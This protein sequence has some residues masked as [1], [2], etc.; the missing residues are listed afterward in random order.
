MERKR[1]LH[2]A[3][4]GGRSMSAVSGV[5]HRDRHRGIR[6]A[7]LWRARRPH[8]VERG[9][10][11][12]Y[13]DPR[14]RRGASGARWRWRDDD[15]WRGDNRRLHHGW[16]R[17]R[18]S[19]G[20]LR[21]A[22]SR[23]HDGRHLSLGHCATR[24]K[25]CARRDHHGMVR[26]H[27]ALAHCERAL[28]M[29]KLLSHAAARRVDLGQR[30][31]RRRYCEVVRQ[32]QLFANLE[33]TPCEFLAAVVVLHVQPHFRQ[34]RQN[35]SD[36]GM[37]RTKRLL[38][39]GKQPRKQRSRRRVLVLAK[40]ESR[41]VVERDRDIGVPFSQVLLADAKRALEQRLR[42]IELAARVVQRREIVDV[43]DETEVLGSQHT[44]ADG[45][46]AM[47]ERLRL[48]EI[49]LF[50]LEL[51]QVA[52]ARRE[53]HVVGAKL[54]RLANRCEE[55]LFGASVVAVGEG[56]SASLV[57]LLPARFYGVVH[58][59]LPSIRRGGAH[60]VTRLS[61]ANFGRENW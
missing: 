53:S 39:D 16:R 6:S 32:L 1:R 4:V 50:V 36:L 43:L 42:L 14:Q 34:A 56:Q 8:A 17:R 35:G 29:A 18:R 60:T 58:S 59:L 19:L 52:Q 31:E 21:C 10:R 45:E 15:S 37:T 48:R 11:L 23:R 5:A 25:R 47:K 46:R 12:S 13:L 51:S 20:R 49:L 41:E 55:R 40:V 44:F 24:L 26:T 2:R 33:R 38:L 54:R 22:R 3:R 27:G 57:L 9:R 30:L 61:T 7:R 28:A